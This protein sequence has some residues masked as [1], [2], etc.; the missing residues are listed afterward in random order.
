M[1]AM[2]QAGLR[3]A[4]SRL[5]DPFDAMLARRGGVIDR[6]DVAQVERRRARHGSYGAAHE[7]SSAS[8]GSLNE[9]RRARR[10]GGRSAARCSFSFSKGR[11][12]APSRGHGRGERD[13]VSKPGGKPEGEGPARKWFAHRYSVSY[14]QAPVFASGAFVDTM[15]VAATWSNLPGLY[16]SVRKALGAHVF[17]MAHLSA[18]LSRRVL[19][20]LLL[21]GKRRDRR[22]RGPRRVGRGVRSH[23]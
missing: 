14:R 19:H 13:A 6:K 3:P 21:R 10:G 2:F 5:Y 15:E 12:T 11:T 22:N 4:V 23:L 20:L 1:R 7:C 16:E 9:S 18:R 8:D 17:V